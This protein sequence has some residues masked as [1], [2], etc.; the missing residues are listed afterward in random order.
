MS[1]SRTPPKVV[2]SKAKP[3]GPL[4]RHPSPSLVSSVS[5]MSLATAK[6]PA[7][8]PIRSGPKMPSLTRWKLS[9]KERG[10]AVLLG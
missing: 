2:F 4:L 6:F 10:A 7:P 5:T 1:T 8:M 3:P 9:R